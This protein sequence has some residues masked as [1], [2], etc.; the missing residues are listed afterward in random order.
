MEAKRQSSAA[1]RTD[2]ARQP[3]LPPQHT[4]GTGQPCVEVA[5]AA[6]QEHGGSQ[7]QQFIN[8]PGQKLEADGGQRMEHGGQNVVEH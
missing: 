5:P 4:A 1:V 6:Q 8:R 2:N 7:N 3:R